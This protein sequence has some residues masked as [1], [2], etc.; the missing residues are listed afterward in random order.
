MKKMIKRKWYKISADGKI[1]GRLATKAAT[2]LMGKNRVDYTPHEDKGAC[3]II[4]DAKK[5]EIG[6]NKA[7]VKKYFSPSTYPGNSK[8]TLYRD[9][10]EEN[11]E[12][13]IYYAVKGM[14][15]KNKLASK[16]MKRLKIYRESEHPHQA[17]DPEE[18]NLN[19]G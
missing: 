1:L 14:L 6:G 3:L 5:V 4:T 9:L 10:I 15:P 8:E 18:I 13:I 19:N 7:E 12:K 17:Q 16:R 2:L 11:P